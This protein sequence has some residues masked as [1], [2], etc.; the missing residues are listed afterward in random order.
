MWNRGSRLKKR[1]AVVSCRVLTSRAAS[2]R[3]FAWVSGTSL[4][5]P[6]VAEVNSSSAASVERTGI[7]DLLSGVQLR[8]Q[9]AG[10]YDICF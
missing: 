4:E 8:N 1:S 3:R 5:V 7:L 9:G 2:A 6:V 10:T